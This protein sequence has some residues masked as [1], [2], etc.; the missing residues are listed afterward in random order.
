MTRK[1]YV[2]TAMGVREYHELFKHTFGPMVA[3]GAGLA[4]QPDRAASLERDFLAFIRRWNRGTRDG[5]VEIPY[6]YLLV[7]ARKRGA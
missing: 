5:R 3:I 6:E 7:V 2:E 1:E 4:S